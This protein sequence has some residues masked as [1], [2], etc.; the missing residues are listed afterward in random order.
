MAKKQI[1]NLSELAAAL[2]IS[3]TQLSNILSNK[4]E[5][6]KA[7]VLELAKFLGVQPTDLIKQIEQEQPIAQDED[8][9]K[10]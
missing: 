7:N 6:I 4:F 2:G 5:P 9:P 8:K 10:P 1:K 3:K